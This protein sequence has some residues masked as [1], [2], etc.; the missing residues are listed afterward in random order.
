MKNKV[1]E[2]LFRNTGTRQTLAKNILW[3]TSSQVGSRLIR[4]IIIVYAARVLGAA[5]YGVFSYALGFATF[6]L[7]FVDIGVNP[8][9][10]KEIAN[11]PTERH[12]YFGTAFWIKLA[13]LAVSA[14]TV[15]FLA[16]HLTNIKEAAA[17]MPLVTLLIIFDGLRDFQIAYLRG[18]ERMEKEA[19]IV[20]TMN[21][22]I[23]FF[24]FIAL[25]VSTTSKALLLS[26][27]G[28]VV[29]SA[30]IPIPMLKDQF[31]N[32][33]HFEARIAREII[34][35]GWPIAL[36][37]VL[38]LFMLNTD[39]IML[40]WWR[41]AEE[42]GHYSAAGRVAQILYTLPALIAVAVFPTLS[43]L[44][45]DGD[46]AKRW[47][48]NER[49]ITALLM[50][51][52][53]LTVGGMLLAT[54]IIQFLFG[55]EYLPAVPIFRILTLTFLIIFPGIFISYAI[56]AYNR[57]RQTVWF[58]TAGAVGNIVL[59]ALLIPRYG[60]IGSAIAT[61]VA[62]LLSYGLSWLYMERVDHFGAP[63]RLAK[64]LAATIVM[65]LASVILNSLGTHILV[66]IAASGSLYFGALYLLKEETLKEGLL[67][68]KRS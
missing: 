65:G 57:Q 62:Q 19:I 41:S 12:R 6:F 7:P 28:G 17:L 11:Q 56:I 55:G 5:E 66:N 33:F 13:F 35:N 31:K 14:L 16:P 20:I 23:T 38:G 46:A 34:K 24:G 26:Y 47:R 49:I 54:P 42:I 2:F 21:V 39:I 51:A 18:L 9:L 61:I 10:T 67:L 30:L 3:L 27:I 60:A 40:G 36:S 8:I 48:L 52:L 32:I 45:K 44:V 37:A 1:I 59:N 22:L 15:I 25:A 68:I 43:R 63:S 58:V 50:V 64:A 29:V 53:P 4:A